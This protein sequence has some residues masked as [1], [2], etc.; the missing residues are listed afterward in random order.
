MTHKERVASLMLHLKCTEAEAEDIIAYDAQV[1]KGEPT[2][3]D[4]TP[5]QMKITKKYR[6]TG[7]REKK[8]TSYEFTQREKKANPTKSAII[9]KIAE[10]LVANG[11][12]AVDITKKEREID[13][14]VG[15]TEFTVMLTQHRAK[16]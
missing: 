5:E 13:F 2:K 16:K 14:K 12:E 4:L 10:M 3:Y 7:T 1:D 9:S 15:E 6:N 11:Y 8:P